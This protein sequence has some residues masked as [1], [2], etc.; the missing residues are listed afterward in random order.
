VLGERRYRWSIHLS[1]LASCF[2]VLVPFSGLS[3]SPLE[4]EW[5]ELFLL[6]G[7]ESVGE[8]LGACEPRSRVGLE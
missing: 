8:K 7:R 1:F 5:G 6:D 2:L 3:R 4:L